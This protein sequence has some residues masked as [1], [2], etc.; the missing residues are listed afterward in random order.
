MQAETLN[1]LSSIMV[2]GIP[3]KTADVPEHINL[4]L[5]PSNP[6]P[7]LWFYFFV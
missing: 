5:A 2:T 7:A 3:P 1:P 6:K 4:K